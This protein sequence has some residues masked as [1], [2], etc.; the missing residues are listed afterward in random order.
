MFVLSLVRFHRGEGRPAEQVR[1]AVSAQWSLL[2]I[3]WAVPYM[4]LG[5]LVLA[6][7]TTLA[8]GFTAMFLA[9]PDGVVFANAG[10]V[11][12]GGAGGLAGVGA[13]GLG[14]AG[15]SEGG[16]D[17]ELLKSQQVILSDPPRDLAACPLAFKTGAAPRL[18]FWV[19]VLA[20]GLL[21][22]LNFINNWFGEY[23]RYN[24]GETLLMFAA[25]LV[26]LSLLVEGVLR[27][28]RRMRLAQGIYRDGKLIEGEVADL[29]VTRSG[30]GRAM[31]Y[32][33]HVQ[34]A[35]HQG[36][37]CKATFPFLDRAL[38]GRVPLL[39]DEHQPGWVGLYLPSQ[40]IDRAH[41]MRDL[42]RLGKVTREGRFEGTRAKVE[43]SSPQESRG[44]PD[45]GLDRIRKDDGLDRLRKGEGLERLRKGDPVVRRDV[46][47]KG[48]KGKL[49][50]RSWLDKVGLVL[51][52]LVL[53][54]GSVPVYFYATRV[55]RWIEVM[56]GISAG[57]YVTVNGYYSNDLLDF[58]QMYDEWLAG[59]ELRQA[60]EEGKQDLVLPRYGD[61][62]M[63]IVLALAL[64]D[65]PRLREV[66]HRWL[67]S[68]RGRSKSYGD[69]REDILTRNFWVYD[70]MFIDDPLEAD[71][72]HV[73][74]AVKAW[75]TNN[76][77]DAKRWVQGFD[78]DARVTGVIIGS[79][80]ELGYKDGWGWGVQGSIKSA[81]A[82]SSFQAAVAELER[83]GALEGDAFASA[84]VALG[85][86]WGLPEAVEMVDRLEPSDR[87]RGCL[88][89]LKR[90]VGSEY[91][92]QRL[93]GETGYMYDFSEGEAERLFGWL[94][95]DP[96]GPDYEVMGA[97][98]VLVSEFQVGQAVD[99][100]KAMGPE[101]AERLR[102]S[103]ELLKSDEG[104]A[105]VS[106]LLAV[107][108]YGRGEDVDAL[109]WFLEGVDAPESWTNR[110]RSSWSRQL[111]PQWKWH[112]KAGRPNLRIVR[113]S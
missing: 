27:W 18:V 33:A 45:D 37:E 24:Q 84:V 90:V 93:D 1:S 113:N 21:V 94:V 10:A 96:P 68:H 41:S 62:D 22:A 39:V 72:E 31:G 14:G 69:G 46:D 57:K 66:Y 75:L 92:V 109:Y 78:S 108:G 38:K 95:A 23:R 55:D 81:T 36:R 56:D 34:Y 54:V 9:G 61:K 63:Q 25:A 64:H 3:L 73:K 49:R 111:D 43:T 71:D 87:Q 83:R 102:L 26:L 19:G 7:T 15:V 77:A 101:A 35:D 16:V 86:R 20:V 85:S 40:E 52:A 79:L 74:I 12:E 8:M 112:R 99:L 53:V 110:L 76:H 13:G 105:R 103:V 98:A 67:L 2:V 104:R 30:S 107:A 50:K 48:S 89:K 59:L 70:R 6:V 32:V 100:F 29:I 82:G 4:S 80:D 88:E 44:V 91:R 97:L 60:K 5:G 17:P 58:L 28:V 11:G 51:L 47:E 106:M 42:F 65:D